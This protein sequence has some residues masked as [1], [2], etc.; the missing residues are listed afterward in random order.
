VPFGNGFG[1]HVRDMRGGAV[2]ARARVSPDGVRIRQAVACVSHYPDTGG[3]KRHPAS[4][5][6]CLT[7]RWQRGDAR[8]SR[9]PPRI[10][11]AARHRPVSTLTLTAGRRGPTQRA[12][13][14]PVAGLALRPSR[15]LKLPAEP[16]GAPPP[17][18]SCRT[19]PQAPGGLPPVW[20]GTFPG[21]SGDGSGMSVTRGLQGVDKMGGFWCAGAES[22]DAEW[23][24]L[25]MA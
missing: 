15:A 17:P 14:Y 25:R 24:V 2:C 9:H 7:L 4:S 13:I 3:S 12:R 11:K 23:R 20:T 8:A 16:A 22:E 5:G 18:S 1:V 19:L 6:T 10:R 21:P